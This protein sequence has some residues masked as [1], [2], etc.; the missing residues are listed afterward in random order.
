MRG[1]AETEEEI[2]FGIAVVVKEVASF[3]CVRKQ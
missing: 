3:F 1:D 2:L